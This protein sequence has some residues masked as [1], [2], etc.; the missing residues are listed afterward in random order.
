MGGNDAVDEEN[1][2]LCCALCCANCGYYNDADCGGC[3]GKAGVCCL[4]CEVC[5]KFGAPCLPCCCCGPVR[6]ALYYYCII[7]WYAVLSTVLFC[8]LSHSSFCIF[9]L[10]H[11]FVYFLPCRNA[12]MMAA[13]CSTSNFTVCAWSF[14]PQSPATMKFLWRWMFWG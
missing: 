7:Y 1:I 14:P 4:N 6:L 13:Q 8:A 10:Y 3:S 11:I 2:V 5:C 9:I 12:K